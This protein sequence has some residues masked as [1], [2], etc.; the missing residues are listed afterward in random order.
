MRILYVRRH[1][2]AEAH[3]R[4][5]SEASAFLDAVDRASREG[6]AAEA[7]MLLEAKRRDQP[8]LPT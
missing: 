2:S 1:G 6:A 7:A 4:Q 5:R 3:D 8:T